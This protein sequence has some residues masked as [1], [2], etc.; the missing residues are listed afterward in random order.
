MDRQAG[1]EHLAI[2]IKALAPS[3]PIRLYF[4]YDWPAS[5]QLVLEDFD[6]A[7]EAVSKA[8]GTGWQRVLAEARIRGQV[9]ASGASA[10]TFLGGKI[11]RLAG[12]A[13][14]VGDRLSF[15]GFKYETSAG[16]FTEPDELANPKRDVAVEVLRQDP[17]CIYLEVMSQWPQL[18]ESPDGTLE[19]SPSKIRGFRSPPSEYLSNTVDYLETTVVPLL[20]NPNPRHG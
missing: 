17:R 3:A 4:Q 7:F 20:T 14:A 19:L 16:D 10:L 11:L 1:Q 13:N 12:D 5:I 2:E 9:D 15:L 18:A 8:L 6:A